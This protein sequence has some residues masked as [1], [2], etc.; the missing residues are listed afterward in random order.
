MATYSCNAGYVLDLSVGS[1][2]RTCRDDDNAMDVI[3]EFDGQAPTCIGK[4]IVY[5]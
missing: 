2:T 5:S 1:K 4:L 3:G